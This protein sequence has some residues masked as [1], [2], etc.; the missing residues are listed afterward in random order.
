MPMTNLWQA[1][2]GPLS[3]D[4]PESPSILIVITLPPDCHFWLLSEQER[5]DS[6]EYSASI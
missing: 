2:F 4:R 5:F 3:R 6:W 1:P